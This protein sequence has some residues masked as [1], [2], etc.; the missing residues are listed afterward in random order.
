[1]AAFL[2]LTLVVLKYFVVFAAPD[3]HCPIFL[4]R[5]TI[6]LYFFLGVFS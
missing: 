2:T 6:I 4:G 3:S 1:M 5:I